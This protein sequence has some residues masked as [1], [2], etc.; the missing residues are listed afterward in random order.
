MTYPVRV[1]NA[2]ELGVAFA[3]DAGGRGGGTGV[4]G[5]VVRMVIGSDSIRGDDDFRVR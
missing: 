5:Q 3:V 4:R 1:V 2:P